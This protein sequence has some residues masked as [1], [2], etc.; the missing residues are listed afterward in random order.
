MTW[1]DSEW[2]VEASKVVAEIRVPGMRI[3]LVEVVSDEGVERVNPMIADEGWIWFPC[4]ETSDVE[5]VVWVDLTNLVVG[6]V[7][8]TVG[9][10]D[11]DLVGIGA[12]ERPAARENLLDATMV[13][14]GD[15]NDEELGGVVSNGVRSEVVRAEVLRSFAELG[16]L[17]TWRCSSGHKRAWRT[18]Q[19]CRVTCD[20]RYVLWRASRRDVRSLV[21]NE[22][23]VGEIW[24]WE[25]A[26][27]TISTSD[28][29]GLK[30]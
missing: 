2:V 1:L 5:V 11:V 26:D 10:G 19:R 9:R 8:R 28:A 13:L 3:A 20:W 23:Q 12:L 15:V 17:V 21:S 7:V 29:S 4:K 18:F 22:S 6:V 30:L 24:R 16:W 14:L 25:G 27:A